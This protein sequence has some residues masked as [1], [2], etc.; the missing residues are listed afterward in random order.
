MQ[1]YCVRGFMP[2]R[3]RPRV[4]GF[5]VHIIQ[6]GHNRQACFFAKADY[7]FYLD[8]LVEFAPRFEC[9][10]HAYVLMTNHVHLLVTP[11][12]ATGLSLLMKFLDQR[13]AQYVNRVYRRSG[14]LWEGR[15]RSSLVRSSRYVLACYRYIEMNPARAN[16]VRHPEDYPWSSYAANAEGKLTTGLTPHPEFLA[17]SVNG[18]RRRLAYRRLF[19]MGFDPELLRDIRVSAHGGLV[20]GAGASGSR[21]GGRWGDT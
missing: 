9:E 14:T 1:A 10:L 15:F 12:L 6:R 19:G 7:E 5:P 3:L 11:Q 2:R 17:L 20:L 16:I 13:Y 8:R 18:E 4:T 21:S